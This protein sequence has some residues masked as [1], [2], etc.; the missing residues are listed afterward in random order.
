VNGLAITEIWLI[1]AVVSVR[2]NARL[3]SAGATK[4]WPR[5]AMKVREVI[6]LLESQGWVE[7]RS[8]AAIGHFKHL[9]L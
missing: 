2:R 3:I 7:I 6:R 8:G 4:A 9:S 5:H 1:S